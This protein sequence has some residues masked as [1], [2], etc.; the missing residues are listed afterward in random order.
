[1][2]D[3]VTG[4]VWEANV[5]KFTEYTQEQALAH[6]AS[7]GFRL[8]TRLE[9]VSLVDFTQPNPTIDGTYFM[10]TPAQK[11]WTSSHF[12]CDPTEAYYVGFDQSGTHPTSISNQNQFFARC[13]KGA[14]TK[15]ASTRY[16][17]QADGSVLDGTTG[18]TW[19]RTFVQSTSWSNALKLCPS[20]W[21]LPSVNE[22]QTIV[23]QNQQSPPIDRVAFPDT[24]SGD[25]WTSSP[26]AGDATQ[27]WY[28]AFIHGHAATDSVAQAFWVR[29]VR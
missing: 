8:P 16:Q 1:V 28:V 13:V 7:I 15:C 2:T 3:H 23:D 27:A 6:C 24:P 22:L 18:L 20:G 4:L 9:L 26:K 14:P 19:Q 25:F 11:Y 17:I 29:C 12:V 21:R 10:N 5:D